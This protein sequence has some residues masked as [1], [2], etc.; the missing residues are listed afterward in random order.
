MRFRASEERFHVRKRLFGLD[1]LT[2]SN[3]KV[4]VPFGFVCKLSGSISTKNSTDEMLTR[5]PVRGLIP[6][7][8]EVGT[9]S[10]VD[11]A[12]DGDEESRIAIKI[13]SKRFISNEKKMMS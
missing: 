11:W 10:S 12:K 8:H 13:N 5:F 4:D 9:S 2:L 1:A 3:V 6:S 7:N